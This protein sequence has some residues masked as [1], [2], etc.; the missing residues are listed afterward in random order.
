MIT[1]A[2]V[3]DFASFACISMRSSEEAGRTFFFFVITT[4]AGSSNTIFDIL[5]FYHIPCA[6]RVFKAH[7][8]TIWCGILYP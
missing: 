8:Q 3:A 4:F 5:K 2:P 7:Q 6:L 1:R